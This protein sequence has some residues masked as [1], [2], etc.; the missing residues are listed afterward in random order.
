MNIPAEILECFGTEHVVI[1]EAYY[2]MLV[3]NNIS[4]MRPKNVCRPTVKKLTELRK[5]GVSAVA[6]IAVQGYTTLPLIWEQVDFG[7]TDD[8]VAPPW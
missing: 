2:P 4:W 3:G 6:V 1:T 8:G 7:L 5:Q